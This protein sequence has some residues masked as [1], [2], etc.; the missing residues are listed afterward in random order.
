MK[1]LFKNSFQN[2]TRTV[3]L[4]KRVLVPWVTHLSPGSFGPVVKEEM[5]IKIFLF[6]ALIAIC[7]AEQKICTILV[8]GI[9]RNISVQLHCILKLDQWFRN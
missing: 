2:F 9:K 8:E 5:S 6:S 4:N 3:V 1:M 7:S